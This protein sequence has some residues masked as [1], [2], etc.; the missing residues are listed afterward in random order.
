MPVLTKTMADLTLALRD[1]RVLALWG[2]ATIAYAI[3]RLGNASSGDAEMWSV[4]A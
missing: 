2:T 1:G 3:V 4:T